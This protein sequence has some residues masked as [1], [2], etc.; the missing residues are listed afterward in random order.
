MHLQAGL[1]E[2]WVDSPRMANLAHLLALLPAHLLAIGTKGDSLDEESA[3]LSD[4]LRLL[5]NC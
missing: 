1:I 5:I 2:P 3:A 4:R